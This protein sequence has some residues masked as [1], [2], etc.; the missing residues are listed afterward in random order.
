[1]N[2]LSLFIK[3]FGTA[4]AGSMVVWGAVTA[5]VMIGAA[6]LSVDTARIYNLDHELQSAA[7]ALARA[8]ATELDQS[9]DAI[10]RANRAVQNLVSNDQ[11]YGAS[12]KANVVVQSTRFLKTL[13]ANDYDPVTSS[14]VTTIPS[15]AHYIE[16]AVAPETVKTF[17]PVSTVRGFASVTLEASAVAGT[18]D[19]V[20]GAAPIFVC[21]PYEGSNVTNIYD[22]MKTKSFQRNLIQF[23]TQSGGNFQYGPGNFGFLDVGGGADALRDAVAIDKPE[24]CF[25]KARGIT[26]EPGNMSS[27]S[28]GFNTR[29]DMYDGSF[30]QKKSDPRY[31]PAANVV[32]GY[33]GPKCKGSADSAALAL[34][35]DSC[36]ETGNCAGLGGRMGDGDWDF[37]E[38]VKINHNAAN[39]LTINGTS[40]NFNY[41]NNTV[42]PT[43]I[44]SR[45]DV[46]RWEIDSNSVP[47]ASTY[48]TSSTP[49]EGLPTCHSSGASI[50]DIDRRIVY[51]AVLNCS[52]IEQAGGLSGRSG[53]HPVETFAK[54]FITR[55]MSNDQDNTIFGEIV[56]PVVAG[57]DSVAQSKIEVVR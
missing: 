20:C 3:N 37:V 17:F 50:A 31:A 9:S 26:T 51:A 18:S 21:N 15:E 13:P 28:Q 39:Q 33:S 48:G 36:F 8:G 45:Y 4:T 49:E 35:L 42:T 44:P 6:A 2:K 5:P 41:T 10:T 53:P 1:M 7:D 24:I 27:V 30:K 19:G 47:G 46:Y 57:Q 16:V 40:F 38:Y 32:K 25:S 56:G 22:A 52:T 54:V 14:M 11:R 55:P 43:S 12:G 23:K 29:F 34:P